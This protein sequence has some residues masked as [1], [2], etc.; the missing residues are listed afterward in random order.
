MS[1]F[2]PWVSQ[3]IKF[4]GIHPQSYFKRLK[5]LQE[6]I[7][8]CSN[9]YCYSLLH[10]HGVNV[11]L[12]LQAHFNPQ[13]EHNN[14]S[15]TNN[16]TKPLLLRKRKLQEQKA[17]HTP[18]QKKQKIMI[19]LTLDQGI[20]SDT[21]NYNIN[22]KYSAPLPKP[23]PGLFEK[24]ETMFIN[25]LK[26]INI[27]HERMITLNSNLIMKY[28]NMNNLSLDSSIY[29]NNKN[30]KKSNI[31]TIGSINA[32]RNMITKRV[33][34]AP[35]ENNITNNIHFSDDESE[36]E[37]ESDSNNEND[38]DSVILVPNE[39]NNKN[40]NK[41]DSDSDSHTESDDG[42]DIEIESATETEYETETNNDGDDIESEYETETE[43]DGDDSE[44][45]S[46]DYHIIYTVNKKYAKNLRRSKRIL[47][48]NKYSSDED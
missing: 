5:E 45:E 18:P 24:E 29:S 28:I 44:S 11:R 21:N 46:D 33:I 6:V 17:D 43:Y 36:S 8:G 39:N 7:P 2:H 16:N 31:N 37:S 25:K 40:K 20:P 4:Y 27:A 38:S 23:H 13:N 15:N 9:E 42:D 48:Q 32:P 30:Q 3:T 35:N 47:R 14:N 22:N 12:A 34:I 26:K 19:D 41:M 10:K 1:G